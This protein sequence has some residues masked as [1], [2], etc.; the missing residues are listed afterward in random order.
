MKT[1]D[2]LVLLFVGLIG[3]VASINTQE[4][5]PYSQ[6]VILIVAGVACTVVGILF[7]Q[8]NKPKQYTPFKPITLAPT[9]LQRTKNAVMVSLGI[10]ESIAL[11]L[12]PIFTWQTVTVGIYRIPVITYINLF[13]IAEF[14]VGLLIIRVLWRYYKAS[15]EERRKFF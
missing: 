7:Y 14:V 9:R 15:D 8:H 5:F 1:A 4:F 10:F 3:V 11:L 2:V 6:I 13:S 12:I